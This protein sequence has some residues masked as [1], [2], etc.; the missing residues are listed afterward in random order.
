MKRR[1][2]AWRE[3]QS[4]SQLLQRSVRALCDPRMKGILLK[5]KGRVAFDAASLDWLQD[6][7]HMV[8]GQIF[9]ARETLFQ[10]FTD[11]YSVVRL[12]HGT[13]V[14]DPMSFYETGILPSDIEML[15]Q[16]AFRL[17]GESPQVVQ[18]IQDLRSIGYTAHSEG[19]IYVCLDPCACLTYD[20]CWRGSEYLSTI[21]NRVGKPEKIKASGTPILLGVD[22]AAEELGNEKMNSIA[23]KAIGSLYRNWLKPGSIKVPIDFGFALLKPVLPKQIRELIQLQEKPIK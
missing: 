4:W 10:A 16:R 7:G 3:F 22:I 21:A 15:N 11:I 13:R 23:G 9:D 8:H 5:G 6:A 18:T 2:F 17:F 14:D 19:K 12:Y 20:Y 1:V